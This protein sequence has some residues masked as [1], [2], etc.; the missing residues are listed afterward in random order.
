M[1]SHDFYH[2]SFTNTFEIIQDV[3]YK[4]IRKYTPS[5][6]IILSFSHKSFFYSLPFYR[7]RKRMNI[8]FLIHLILFRDSLK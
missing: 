3:N 7:K 2:D 4:Y 6:L 8:P 1:L 5:F